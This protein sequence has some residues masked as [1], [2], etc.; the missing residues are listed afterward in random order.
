[1]HTPPT[2]VRSP[3]HRARR[4][5]TPTPWASPR[6]QLY[7]NAWSTCYHY[8]QERVGSS[9]VRERER[10][11]PSAPRARPIAPAGAEDWSVHG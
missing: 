4:T 2:T 6:P 7:L 9:V 8:G 11:A 1:M 10:R 3:R 5:S